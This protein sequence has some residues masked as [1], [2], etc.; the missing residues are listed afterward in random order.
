M[1]FF[2]NMILEVHFQTSQELQMLSI[3][4][5]YRQV[6]S[7]HH[8]DQM[9]QMS[10]VS[11]ISLWYQKV[12][13]PCIDSVIGVGIELSQ[14]K[15][16]TAK[17]YTLLPYHVWLLAVVM[18]SSST[19]HWHCADNATRQISSHVYTPVACSIHIFP[20]LLV[21]TSNGQYTCAGCCFSYIIR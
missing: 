12:K 14:T 1:D 16:W 9:F 13:S 17:K 7:P 3:V 8:S 15:V 18:S 4:T 19:A 21:C 20:W 2:E 6:M 10:Q 5:L 11:R